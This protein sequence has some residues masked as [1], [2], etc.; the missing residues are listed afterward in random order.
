MKTP[1]PKI[2]EVTLIQEELKPMKFDLSKVT[3]VITPKSKV[4]RFTLDGWD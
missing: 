4:R 1:K 3:S 2:V